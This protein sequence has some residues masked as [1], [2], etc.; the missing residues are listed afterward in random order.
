MAT[1]ECIRQKQPM[2]GWL[3]KAKRT[4][5]HPVFVGLQFGQRLRCRANT[6]P[7]NCEYVMLGV[8]P[9]FDP[10]LVKCWVRWVTLYPWPDIPSPGDGVRPANMV[11]W[12]NVGLMLAQC[13]VFAGRP[14]PRRTRVAY[15]NLFMD[16]APTS[17][18]MTRRIHHDAATILPGTEQSPLAAEMLVSCSRQAERNHLLLVLSPNSGS[19]H[20][21]PNDSHT[22]YTCMVLKNSLI[23]ILQIY[24]GERMT[25]ALSPIPWSQFQ[26]SN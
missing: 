12:H 16:C 25:C 20:L 9:D 5:R 2:A 24:I 8:Y 19:W 7:E 3:Q 22:W 10:M 17:R 23:V 26:I 15:S 13:T 18:H 1:R 4:P 14:A 21:Q 11:H 6:K